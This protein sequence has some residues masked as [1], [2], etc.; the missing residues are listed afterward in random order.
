MKKV[1]ILGAT[2]SIGMQAIEVCNNLNYEIV[3]IT[4]NTNYKQLAN[5]YIKNKPKYMAIN[6]EKHY[7]LLK[8]IVDGDINVGLSGIIEVIKKSKAD[9][10]VNAIVGSAGIIPTIEAIKNC[11]RLAI[12]NKETFVS[13][14]NIVIELA[15]QYN[16][17]ILPV[18]SEHS[19]IYQCLDG[20]K[21]KKIH[22][23]AS[24]G[25]FLG[26]SRKQLETVTKK[27]ALKHPN[28]EM[29]SK[30]TIDSATMM[31]KGLEVIEAKWLFN[32]KYSDINVL[33]HKQ[34]IVHSLVEYED[35]SFMAQLG[36]HDMRI[37]IQYALTYP[38][39]ITNQFNQLNLVEIGQ[40]NFEKPD[41]DN[42][43]CLKLAYDAIKAGNTMPVVLNAANEVA[44]S[45]FLKEKITFVE[46]PILIEKIMEKHD[47]IYTNNIEEIL[48]IDKITRV[49]M[50]N[51]GI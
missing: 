21:I 22:L 46:I 2:G 37:P 16:C 31:N 39:R 26:Y 3:G 7:Q 15:K 11:K 18:D 29:G 45:M 49:K 47:N 28:W 30:I 40:L 36:A 33:I 6:S 14:G 27:D 38:K 17:E 44:V 20:Q 12:A 50:I 51:G 8:E 24:G 41:F 35:N 4:A 42:F 32:V 1:L 34:S 25:P 43:R 10:I 19:A 13:A 5:I 9:I 48:E 23:T